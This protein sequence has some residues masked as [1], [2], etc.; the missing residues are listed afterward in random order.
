MPSIGF[1]HVCLSANFWWWRG[2]W[3]HSSRRLPCMSEMQMRITHGRAWESENTSWILKMNGKNMHLEQS[4]ATGSMLNPKP[5]VYGSKL[6]PA[7]S[8][9]LSLHSCVWHH[10]SQFSI[11]LS[12]SHLR[13]TQSKMLTST[14]MV[15]KGRSGVSW[16]RKSRGVIFCPRQMEF[17]THTLL[18]CSLQCESLSLWEGLWNEVFKP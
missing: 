13:R 4:V 2:I 10:K 14:V 1:V 9:S 5:R 3:N 17:L 16:V 6:N 12:L 8:G 15:L 11:L 18:S 7:R